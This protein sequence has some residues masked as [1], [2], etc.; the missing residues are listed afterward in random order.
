MIRCLLDR[1]QD[2]AFHVI[3]LDELAAAVCSSGEDEALRN[4]ASR[5]GEGS[6]SR[7][8][9]HRVQGFD[10]SAREAT[11]DGIVL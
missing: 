5:A 8:G 2:L 3:S 9:R 7:N 4:V 10:I 11:M 6:S 1:T